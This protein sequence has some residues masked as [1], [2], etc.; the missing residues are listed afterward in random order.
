MPSRNVIKNKEQN[1]TKDTVVGIQDD[2]TGRRDYRRAFMTKDTE[3]QLEGDGKEIG[4]QWRTLCN[5]RKEAE[6]LNG[7]GITLIDG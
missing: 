7:Q 2:D 6:Q 4:A 1:F 3:L 5:N